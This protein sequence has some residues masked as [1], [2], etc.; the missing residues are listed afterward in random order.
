[1]V[2]RALIVEEDQKE[3]VRELRA[4]RS[5]SN[6]SIKVGSSSWIKNVKGDDVTPKRNEANKVARVKY[7]RIHPENCL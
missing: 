5:R 4:K 3:I 6:F 7:E 1:M 2:S